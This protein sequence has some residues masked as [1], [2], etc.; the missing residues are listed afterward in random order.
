M[1]NENVNEQNEAQNE[2]IDVTGENSV[3][4]EQVITNY[5]PDEKIISDFFTA[6]KTEVTSQDLLKAGF[7]AKRMAAYTFNI[8]QYT[9][10]RF[11]LVSPYTIEKNT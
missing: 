10:S 4:V 1:M 2:E 6:G 11:M 5:D 8:G 3:V 9:L 7:D